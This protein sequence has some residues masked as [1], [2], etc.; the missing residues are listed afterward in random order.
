MQHSLCWLQRRT[1][2]G[3]NPD[4]IAYFPVTLDRLIKLPV[5]QLLISKTEVTIPTTYVGL[6]GELNELTY[7]NYLE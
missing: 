1:V 2:K 6:L 3:S 4:S 5:S 7:V